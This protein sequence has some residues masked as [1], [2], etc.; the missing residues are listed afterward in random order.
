MARMEL[1]YYP[2]SPWHIYAAAISENVEATPRPK[3]A[4]ESGGKL[5]HSEGPDA[6]D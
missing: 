2:F 5:P 6:H 4:F 1:A 3:G